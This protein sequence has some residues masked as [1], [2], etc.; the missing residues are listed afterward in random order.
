[1]HEFW[2]LYLHSRI[3]IN[4]N[5]R[6]CLVPQASAHSSPQEVHDIAESA[7]AKIMQPNEK[8]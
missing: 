3:T 4:I 6:K 8:S 2:I 5:Y 7:D 1:M